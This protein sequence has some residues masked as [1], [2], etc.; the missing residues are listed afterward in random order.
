MNITIS[1][2]QVD[3]III[4]GLTEDYESCYNETD[5]D[6]ELYRGNEELIPQLKGVIFYYLNPTEQEEFNK[7]FPL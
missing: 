1:D 7:R 6:G 5:E 4:K 2:D 3:K